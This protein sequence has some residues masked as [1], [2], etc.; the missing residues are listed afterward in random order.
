MNIYDGMMYPLEK[1]W[2]AEKRE[3][4]MRYVKGE[5]LEI[6]YGTGSNFK[7]MNT[8][9]IHHITALDTSE[10]DI[11][12][13]D[14]PIHFVTGSVEALPF[15]NDFF[16]TV[17]ETLVLCSVNELERSISEIARVLKPGG[18]FVYMDHVLPNDAGLAKAF[19]VVNP[20]WSKIANG[21]Q[22]VRTPKSL[23]ERY[24]LKIVEGHSVGKGIFDYGIA[25]KFA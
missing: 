8:D 3:W 10:N 14:L 12:R 13:N 25:I 5:V 9:A 18:T 11:V 7:F 23:F 20:L 19:K 22:L 24:N 17:I 16:D 15:E 6:G 2:L 21:C 4:L 1:K